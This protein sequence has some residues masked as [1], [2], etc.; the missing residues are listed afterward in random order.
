MGVKKLL[1]VLA[2]LALTKSVVI[3]EPVEPVE[4]PPIV[5]TVETEEPELADATVVKNADFDIVSDDE[6]EAS[7]ELAEPILATSEDAYADEAILIAE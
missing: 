4:E 1:S 2:A 3:G 7:P 6:L 5:Y